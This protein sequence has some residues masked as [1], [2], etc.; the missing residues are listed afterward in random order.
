VD[1]CCTGLFWAEFEG[2]AEVF[3]VRAAWKRKSRGES[4]VVDGS[5]ASLAACGVGDGVADEHELLDSE[6]SWDWAS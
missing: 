4:R 2:D 5:W 3:S 6:D 1:S